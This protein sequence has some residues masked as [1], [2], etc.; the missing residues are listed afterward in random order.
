VGRLQR[1]LFLGSSAV[2][3]SWHWLKEVQTPETAME[4]EKQAQRSSVELTTGGKQDTI[5]SHL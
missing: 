3:A 4:G 2:W 1:G 5:S